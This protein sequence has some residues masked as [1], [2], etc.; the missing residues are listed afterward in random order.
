VDRIAVEPFEF[1]GITVYVSVKRLNVT[2]RTVKLSKSL[3]ILG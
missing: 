2:E 1:P 3:R